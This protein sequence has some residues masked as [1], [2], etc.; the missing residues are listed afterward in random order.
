MSPCG[1]CLVDTCS[2]VSIA[3]RDVL[4]GVRHNGPEHA[5]VVGHLGGETIL[6]DA[7][8][9]ELDRSDGAAP[10][11]LTDVYVVEP[12]MLPAGV[13]A[14]LGVADVAALGISIDHVLSSPGCPW[15]QALPSTLFARI[16][17]AF[18]RC[19]GFGPPP[20]RQNPPRRMLPTPWAREVETEAANMRHAAPASQ[21]ELESGRA[22]LEATK[23]RYSEEQR[24]R[25]ANR[26]SELFREGLAHKQALKARKV[27]AAEQLRDSFRHSSSEDSFRPSSSENPFR[28]VS[29]ET[30]PVAPST[31]PR[32]RTKF[33]AVRKGRKT[34]IFNAW[35]EWEKLT[36]GVSSEFKSFGSYEEASAYLLG[37]RLNFMAF[38]RPVKP[39]SSFV[40]GNALRAQV[41]VWQDGHEDALRVECGLDT[42]SDVNLALAVLLHDI[43]D[44]I[45]DDVRGSAGNTTFAKEGTLKL[46]YEGEVVSVP[47]LVAVPSQ[48]PRSCDVSLGIPGLNSLGV[49]I[50]EHRLAQRQ[51]LMCHVGEKTL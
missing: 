22:L 2:D 15:E 43:H 11:E 47:A 28:H 42:M 25:T 48:L 45:V 1:R 4:A 27:A 10:V 32:K 3:R 36:K 6:Q 14:L 35:E 51:P 34:G 49:R 19:F 8:T 33:Y 41:D 40:G 20:E 31:W 13:I 7:G 9:F 46:L 21:R 23:A 12:D 39:P 38:R 50:D 24:R 17:R 16:K 18:R 37:R 44:I 30:L 29:S 5:V 26:V